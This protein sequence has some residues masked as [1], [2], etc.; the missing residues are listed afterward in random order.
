[1]TSEI[2][3]GAFSMPKRETA[4]AAAAA[5]EK[6]RRRRRRRQRRKGGC[7]GMRERLGNCNN[8]CSRQTLRKLG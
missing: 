8:D 6:R 3:L 7:G 4:A 1:M 2:V 5:E